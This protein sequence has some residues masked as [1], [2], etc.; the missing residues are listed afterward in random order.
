MK[1][2]AS[3]LDLK[4]NQYE[5]GNFEAYEA[6]GDERFESDN[7]QDIQDWIENILDQIAQKI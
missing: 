6:L 5:D 1:V 4:V 3:W 7:W 2:I